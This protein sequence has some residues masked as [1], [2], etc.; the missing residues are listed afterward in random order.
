[1]FCACRYVRDHDE[2]LAAGAAA[3]AEGMRQL[4]E[5]A[6]VAG[7]LHVSQGSQLW[8]AA[9]Q[10]TFRFVPVSSDSHVAA[11]LSCVAY[12][13]LHMNTC[14]VRDADLLPLPCSAP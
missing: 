7:G 13:N 5:R 10:G 9:R 6:L 3:A 1:M 12:E 2:Q 11:W 4:Y 14:A 8:N